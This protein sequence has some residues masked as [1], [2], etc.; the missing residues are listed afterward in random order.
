MNVSSPLAGMILQWPDCSSLNARLTVNTNKC[1]VTRHLASVGAVTVTV[2]CTVERKFEESQTAPTYQVKLSFSW[3]TCFLFTETTF[4]VPEIFYCFSSPK[5][6]TWILLL[7]RK[8]P[9][10]FQTMSVLASKTKYK[11]VHGQQISQSSSLLNAMKMVASKLYNAKN[12]LAPV[13]V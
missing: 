13:G 9:F 6:G 1:S 2:M 4:T 3:F 8:K 11:P 12:Q 5:V 7:I 10:V